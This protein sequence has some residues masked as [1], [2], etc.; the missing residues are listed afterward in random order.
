MNEIIPL[1]PTVKSPSN[2]GYFT[3]YFTERLTTPE[4][5][6]A[7]IKQGISTAFEWVP[8]IFS[9]AGVPVEYETECRDDFRAGRLKV[10]AGEVDPDHQATLLYRPEYDLAITE[11]R[12]K[13]SLVGSD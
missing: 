5:L 12:S 6:T 10:V 4:Q 8:Y 1:V 9:S 3:E 11:E 2:W 13:V 7:D